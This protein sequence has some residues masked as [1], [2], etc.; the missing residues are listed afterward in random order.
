MVRR[1]L[2]AHD[3][4]RGDAGTVAA[5]TL[6]A[7]DE[8][9]VL[10]SGLTAHI[11]GI[12]TF[13][14]MADGTEVDEAVPPMA[15]TVRLEDAVDVSRGDMICRPHNRPEV[16]QDIDAML[17]WMDSTAPLQPG[18]IYRLKHTTRTVRAMVTDLRYR[19]DI[20]SMHRDEEATSLVLNEIGRAVIR[21]TEPIF[22]DDYRRNRT[23]GSFVLMDEVTNQTVAGGMI[24]SGT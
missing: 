7:G 16:A 6:K 5:G 4:Y 21:S 3:D 13:D 19:L 15:V 24:R 18:T 11:A 22:V 10:P 8:V 12:D 14:T 23:T 20:N 17:C 9:V 1:G 2:R